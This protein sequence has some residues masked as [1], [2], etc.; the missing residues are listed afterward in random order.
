M[1]SARQ[2]NEKLMKNIFVSSFTQAAAEQ[3]HLIDE[4]CAP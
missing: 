1:A 4:A 3:K 2:V